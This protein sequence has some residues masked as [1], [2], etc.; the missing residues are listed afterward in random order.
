MSKDTPSPPPAP[1]Y[2]GAAT[3]QGQ[4]NLTAAQQGAVLSN[5]NV[6]S[7]YGNQTVTWS[8]SDPN[9]PGGGQQATVTQSLTPDAQK[10]LTAQ[11]QVQYQLAQ[12]GSQ[13]IGTAQSA[14]AHPFSGSG[15]GLDRSGPGVQSITGDQFGTAQGN[16]DLSNVAQMPVNAGMTG[17]QAIMSRLQPQIAQSNAAMAAQLANQGVTQGSEAYNNAQRTQQQGNNDLLSQA[18][19]QGI[20]L[21]MGAN[22]QGYQQA[23]QSAGLYN[24]AVGQ[25][26]SQGAA[27][28]NQNF[29]QGLQ[30]AQYQNATSQSQLQQD[31]ALRN[32][33]LN[34]ISAL[35]SGSQIQN[36]QFQAYQG[37]NVQAA[38]VFQAAQAQG[39]NAMDLY[40]IQSQNANANTQAL[41]G[42]AGAGLGMFKFPSDRRLKSRIVRVGTLRPGIGIYEYDIAD[43]RELGVIAQEVELILPHAVETHPAGF[44][45]VDYGA[46]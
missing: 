38:P 21:D 46:L 41:Y 31:L 6:V 22:Q 30:S 18:A 10:A 16:L 28:A 40:G 37:Q 24:T 33:P 2:A 4:A 7:P 35:M 34:E 3:A 29:N 45:M 20:N 15:Y 8:P 42:L 1:D 5:P 39:Q 23:L 44:K 14:L 25:N 32:Q 43:R 17:Q 12:L 11:Q 36:P 9:N 26:F 27:A 13:G 19:L